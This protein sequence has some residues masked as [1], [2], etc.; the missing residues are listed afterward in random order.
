M[1]KLLKSVLQCI[2]G[3]ELRNKKLDW[4]VYSNWCL[5]EWNTCILTHKIFQ[6]VETREVKTA[7]RLSLLC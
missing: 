2:L 4:L 3:L 7:F 6:N 5:S 1:Q